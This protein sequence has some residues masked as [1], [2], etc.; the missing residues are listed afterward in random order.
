MFLLYYECMKTKLKQDKDIY[1]VSI[2]GFLDPP[3]M[4][5]FKSI[6]RNNFKKN[7]IVFNLRSLSFV[8]S[9]GIDIFSK[10]L[11]DLNKNNNL[12]LCCV[13]SEFQKLF[14]HENL[15]TLICESEEEAVASFE[16]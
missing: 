12:K 14:Q 10:I 5:K 4:D 6:C 7:K 9:S 15:D 2:E 1:V 11:E 16:E 8:G 3:G 13:S